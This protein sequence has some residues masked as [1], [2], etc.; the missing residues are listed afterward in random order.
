MGFHTGFEIMDMQTQLSEM[1]ASRQ[2]KNATCKTWSTAYNVANKPTVFAC[3][4][5]ISSLPKYNKN[6]SCL[7]G[8]ACHGWHTVTC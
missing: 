4:C 2:G 1:N 5:S 3:D 6:A 8:H 7:D